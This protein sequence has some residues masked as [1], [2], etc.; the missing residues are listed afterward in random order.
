MVLDAPASGW[1]ET[2]S[3]EYLKPTALKSAA[4]VGHGSPLPHLVHGGPGRAGGGE[5]MGGIRG[6]LHY[7][8]RTAI[9]SSPTTLTSITS[10]WVTGAAQPSDKVAVLHLLE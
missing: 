4:T 7:M 3:S 10:E 2:S 5:E 1:V 9:Q 6:V 8:Q